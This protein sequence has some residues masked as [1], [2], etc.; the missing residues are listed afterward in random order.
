[1][2][3]ENVAVVANGATALTFADGAVS[4]SLVSCRLEGAVALQNAADGLA[5][6]DSV[7]L[8]TQKTC[9]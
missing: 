5:L 2:T 8:F 3:F 4:I 6:T 1:M 9:N 7:I